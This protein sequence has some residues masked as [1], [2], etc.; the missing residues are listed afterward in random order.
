MSTLLLISVF[1]VATCGLIYEL[2][3]GSLASYLLGDSITQ[4]STIIGVYLFSMG[5]GSWLS[6]YIH[7]NLIAKFIQVEI[8]IGLVGGFSAAILFLSFDWIEHFRVLLYGMVTLIGTLVGLEIPLL[9]RILKDRF[10]FKDLVSNVFTF[11]CVGALVASLL[12]PLLLVP[13]VGIMRTSFLFG[14]LNVGVAIFTLYRFRDEMRWTYYLKGQ[15]FLALALLVFGFA[16]SEK[17]LSW[18]EVAAYQDKVIFSKTSPYQKIVL[19]RSDHDLRLFLNGNLQF[20]SD[21]EYRYHEALV[22]PAAAGQQRLRKVLVLGGGDGLA[23]REILRYPQV[24]R[25]MLVDLDPEMTRLFKENSELQ[26]LNL[27]ALNDSR[28]EIVNQ[29]AFSWLRKNN[30][31]FDLIIIDFPDPS[32]FSLGK[33]YSQ[34]FYRQLG[35]ALA[36]NGRFAVQSTSPY[37]AKRSFWI[38]NHT[39]RASGFETV[40]YHAYVPSFGEWGFILGARVAPELPLSLPKDLRFLNLQT[41]RQMTEFPPDMLVESSEVNRLNNQVLVRTFEDEWSKYTQ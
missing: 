19:T 24:E 26:L 28:V 18:A 8:L 5:I 11:D 38:I 30:E 14:L 27:N 41:M 20:S 36:P 25:I 35:L 22:H 1:V 31:V 15:G 2:I 40:P 10:E 34:S 37:F 16:Y 3:A 13:H 6:K 32:N 21:D 7:R 33:L 29:D 23:A 39:I 9:M 17:L 4:F 12:F